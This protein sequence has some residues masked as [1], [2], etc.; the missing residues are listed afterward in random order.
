MKYHVV[1]DVLDAGWSIVNTGEMHFLLVGLG[2]TL[3][4][5]V[6][7]SR[8][9][10]YIGGRR[11]SEV[12]PGKKLAGLLLPLLFIL[13]G[14]WEVATNNYPAYLENERFKEWVRLGDYETIEG[15][16]TNYSM[17]RKYGSAG[18][19]V[20]DIRFTYPRMDHSTGSFRGQFSAPGT[21]DLKLENGMKVRIA[22]RE[23]RI[24]RMEIA[25]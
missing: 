1:Y 17:G 18:F 15:V 8:G 9:I 11:M 25:K 12:D 10:G 3:L 4:L 23:G 2:L 6:I 13:V 16:I 22:H 7:Y 21:E 14:A 24:L 5:I 20:G 19:Q